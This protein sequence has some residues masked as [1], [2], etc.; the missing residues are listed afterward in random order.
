MNSKDLSSF[1]EN[2]AN[3]CTQ[4]GSATMALSKWYGTEGY[5]TLKS[6]ENTAFDIVAKLKPYSEIVDDYI[7]S[8]ATKVVFDN[9]INIGKH[10]VDLTNSVSNVIISPVVIDAVSKLY[11]VTNISAKV[12]TSSIEQLAKA[13]EI[14]KLP[15]IVSNME[16]LL[17][18][19]EI[20]EMYAVDD[21]AEFD[22]SAVEI[23]DD[24]TLLING[25]R[26]TSEEIKDTLNVE[27]RDIKDKGQNITDLIEKAKGSLIGL[28][29]SLLLF[30]PTVAQAV[31]FYDDAIPYVKAFFLGENV[32][33]F[34][35][36][37]YSFLR[38]EANSKAKS[39]LRIPYDTELEVLEDVSRWY[40]VRYVNDIGEEI[41]G[42]ISKVSVEIDNY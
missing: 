25:S 40:K 38:E 6:L 11:S 7:T 22:F 21:I 24:N 8:P 18:Q 23:V 20:D 36:K 10:Y 12:M 34:T 3:M 16:I 14:Y 42:W 9:L 32:R 33:C 30:I 35:I 41:V 4:I 19:L 13:V 31:E 39:L 15:A 27:I 5:R 26:Y 37:E 29:I 28:L 1:L 17:S 2:Y